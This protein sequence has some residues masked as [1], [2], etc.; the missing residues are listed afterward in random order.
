MK[1]HKIHPL[2]V[3]PGNERLALLELDYRELDG[4]KQVVDNTLCNCD[5]EGKII[6]NFE[7]GICTS[8]PTIST[9]YDN[10]NKRPFSP[11]KNKRRKA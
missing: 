8:N 4:L 1:I 7:E 2:P 5:P 9:L 3:K 6:L 11:V 10:K